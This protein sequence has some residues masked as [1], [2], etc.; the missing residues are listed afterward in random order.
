MKQVSQIVLAIAVVIQIVFEISI[1]RAGSLH[2]IGFWLRVV[3]TIGFIGLL[4]RAD[5]SNWLLASVRVLIGLNFGLAVC[6][7]FGLFGRYGSPGV[8]WGDF[9]HFVVYT[10]QVNSFLPASFAP[11]LAVAATVCEIVLCVTLVC[12]IATRIACIGAALLLLTYAV[13]MTFSLGFTSQLYYAVLE[14]CAGA[15]FLSTIAGRQ[16][17]V[18]TSVYG[19]AVV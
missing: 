3:F 16:W 5:R 19:D 18:K 1:F 11:F 8:S 7:R 10:H 15:W 17:I 4:L 2:E 6:D 12:G 13:T 14:L 9:G